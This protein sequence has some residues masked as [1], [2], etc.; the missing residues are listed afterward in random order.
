MLEEINRK[1]LIKLLET[2]RTEYYKLVE[3]ADDESKDFFKG[4]ADL[5]DDLIRIVRLDMLI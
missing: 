1:K 4:K 3:V 2:K 5:A